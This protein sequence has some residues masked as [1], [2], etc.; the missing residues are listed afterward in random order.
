MRH[1]IDLIFFFSTIFNNFLLILPFQQMQLMLHSLF[2]VPC[3]H[4]GIYDLVY[5]VPR[6]EPYNLFTLLTYD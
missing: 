2:S 4:R 5:M 6:E 3:G 1:L